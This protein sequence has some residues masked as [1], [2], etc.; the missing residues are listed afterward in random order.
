M[1]LVDIPA[2]AL[3]SVPQPTGAKVAIG[4]GWKPGYRVVLDEVR[5]TYCAINPPV[6]SA[7]E[8]RLQAWLTRGQTARLVPTRPTFWQ[9]VRRMFGGWYE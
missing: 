1:Q 4:T 2:S 3:R 7:F 9:R 8:M 6:E 5:G